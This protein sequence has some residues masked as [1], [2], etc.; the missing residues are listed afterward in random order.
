MS[1]R[2]NEDTSAGPKTEQLMNNQVYSEFKD[3]LDVVIYQDDPNDN[4][5]ID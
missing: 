5:T 3:K 2:G 4:I 1:F